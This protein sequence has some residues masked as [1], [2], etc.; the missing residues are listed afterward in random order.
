MEQNSTLWIIISILISG[1]MISTAIVINGS[2]QPQE[3]ISEGGQNPNV[4]QEAS[5]PDAIEILDQDPYQGNKDE[6][7]IGIIEFS[8]YQCPFC[9][10]F[11][12]EARK[13]LKEDYVDT[14]EAVVVWKDLPQQG[15]KS[16]DYAVAAQCVGK[17]AGNE[18]YFDYSDRLYS[19]I[20]EENSSLNEEGLLDLAEEVGANREAVASCYQDREIQEFVNSNMDLAH[21][22]GIRGTPGIVIG[23][24]EDGQLIDPVHIPGAQPISVFEEAI[25]N[26]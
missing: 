4:P 12:N 25:D 22:F 26:L 10:T 21:E 20:H 16:V 8:D 23:K 18:G 5:L 6:A 13:D 24:L 1:A 11:H 19:A 2:A 9:N 15:Q 3:Q 7:S 14:G 17:D